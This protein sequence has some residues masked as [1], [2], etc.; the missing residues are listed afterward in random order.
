[1]N[2][3]A[4][5]LLDAHVAHELA[6]LKGKKLKKN[7]NRDVDLVWKWME[8]TSVLKIAN[9]DS[10]KEFLDRNVKS[11]ETPE[12]LKHFIE[13]LLNYLYIIY[14]ED[15]TKLTSIVEKDHFDNIVDEIAEQ[16]ELRD[17]IIERAV[18]NPFYAEVIT[19]TLFNGI[20]SFTSSD[21]GVAKKVPGAS[22]FLKF[23]QGIL[24]SAIPNLE[25]TIDKNVK[26]FISTN[27]RKIIGQSERYI[28]EQLDEAR[29]KEFAGEVW[30][31]MEGI[32]V[33]N[34]V[35]NIDSDDFEKG[36]KIS[37]EVWTDLKS[38]E[39]FDG[40]VEDILDHFFTYHEESNIADV[41]TDL[42]ID[43]DLIKKEMLIGSDMVLSALN[44]NGF[45]ESFIKIRLK[46]FYDSDVVND[47]LG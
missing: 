13:D 9:K 4:E 23:G 20:K 43:T 10:V 19:N 27:A 22:S 46:D 8:R 5:K 17:K 44:E 12:G 14:K 1:M 16:K 26:K 31:K 34:I 2:K 36:I 32:S 29:I 3:T 37:D 24:N 28:K 42:S 40:L 6:Q 47:I 21:D 33:G 15:K 35:D 30:N 45:L 7:I 18:G 39:F 41:L 38:N 25:E 11:K